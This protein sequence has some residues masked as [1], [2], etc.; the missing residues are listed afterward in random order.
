MNV[1]LSVGPECYDKD[2]AGIECLVY[3]I[4]VNP[5]V[6]QDSASDETGQYRDFLCHLS[7][8][9]VEQKYP[10]KGLLDK[11]YKLPKLAYMGAVIRSQHIRDKKTIPGIHDI[12]ETVSRESNVNKIIHKTVEKIPAPVERELS[13]SLYWIKKGKCSEKDMKNRESIEE[14]SSSSSSSSSSSAEHS[15]YEVP[16]KDTN[17][18]YGLTY[19]E[20]TIIPDSDKLR[21]TLRIHFTENI[22]VENLE[23]K[24]SPYKFQVCLSYVTINA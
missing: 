15:E 5:K 10:N 7:I 17:K 8:Q 23:V 19:I 6:I 20:P 1:P 11:Q 4:I 9:S 2:H 3:D 22:D 21:L 18:L 12:S 14:P 13:Y 16:F 24:V